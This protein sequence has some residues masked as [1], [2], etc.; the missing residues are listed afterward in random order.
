MQDWS[1]P[2]TFST[3]AFFAWV[4]WRVRP[5][6]GWGRRPLA[7]RAEVRAARARIAQAR[8]ASDRALALCD[9]ADIMAKTIGGAPSAR[10]LYLR[11]LRS[12]PGSAAIVQRTAAGL[13]SR[14]RQ[15]ESLLWRHLALAPWEGASRDA[16]RASLD[17]LRSLYEG[18]LRSSTRARALAHAHAALAPRDNG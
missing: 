5:A 9:A 14:P 4:I 2:L 18:P 12:D 8:D 15:L 1:I 6:T 16:A 10:G 7:S 11:A 17:I 13:A 3:A